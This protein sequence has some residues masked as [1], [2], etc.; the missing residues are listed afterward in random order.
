M[1]GAGDIVTDFSQG[2]GDQIDL[3]NIDANTPVAGNQAFFLGGGAFT[4]LAG[5]LIQFSS[6]GYTMVQGDTNGDAVADPEMRV[7]GTP[8]LVASGFVMQPACP[9]MR[10]HLQQGDP[11]IRDILCLPL[12]R[13]CR[14]D[15]PQAE[16]ALKNDYFF[17]MRDFI[18]S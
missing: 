14:D 4:H 15:G 7:A 2:E 13:K 18:S 9:Y 11:A 1:V 3:F 17:S 16:R 5:Q 12:E 10:T 6:G 8:A